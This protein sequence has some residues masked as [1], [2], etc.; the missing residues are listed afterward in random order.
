MLELLT[1]ISKFYHRWHQLEVALGEGIQVLDFDYC[2]REYLIDIEPPFSNRLEALRHLEHLRG[3]LADSNLNKLCNAEFLVQKLTGAA[4][5]LRALMG[6][7]SSFRH[8]LRATM[9]I[10]PEPMPLEELGAMHTELEQRFSKL[11]IPFSREGKSAFDEYMV[12]EDVS[13]FGDT[14]R[15]EANHWVNL[16]QQRIGLTTQPIYRIEVVNEDAYWSNW[17]DGSVDTMIRLRINTH[18]RITF[19]KGSETGFAVHEIGGHALQIL[20]LD[21]ARQVGKV[22]GAALNLAVHSCE[23]FQLEGLAQTVMFLVAE[24]GEIPEALEVDAKLRFYHSALTNNAQI[25]LE[26]GRPIDEVVEYLLHQAPFLAPLK[27]LSDLRDRQRHPLYRA[28]MYVY[29][30]S[31]RK[32]LAASSLPEDARKEFLY[33]MYTQLWT[34]DQINAMLKVPSTSKLPPHD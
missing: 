24:E 4:A 28:Y 33:H 21:A 15:S 26:A 14:L 11:N 25:E 19:L 6:E 22:D 7:R 5:F 27:A 23:Q 17:I 30:P 9:G 10:D 3:L 12:M 1:S 29:A 18:P 31:R 34:P 13:L 8:Y 32:F 16:L 20:E 2:P